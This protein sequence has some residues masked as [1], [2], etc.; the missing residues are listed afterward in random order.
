MKVLIVEAEIGGKGKDRSA[1]AKM[2]TGAGM[3]AEARTSVG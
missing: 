1:I 3:W 2:L